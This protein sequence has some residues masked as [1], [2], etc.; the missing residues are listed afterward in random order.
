MHN[1]QFWQKIFEKL[2]FFDDFS[3]KMTNVRPKCVSWRSN[4]E[5]RSIGAATVHKY[6]FKGYVH[7]VQGI[8]YYL[9]V[10]GRN[11]FTLPSQ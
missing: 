9:V 6:F 8:M 11:L 5:W 7:I 10:K 4:Q 3:S 2:L 1:G